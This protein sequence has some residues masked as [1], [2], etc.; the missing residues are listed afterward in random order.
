MF[1]YHQSA[2]GGETGAMLQMR[3]RSNMR[4]T[5]AA[6]IAESKCR[7][8]PPADGTAIYPSLFHLHQQSPRSRRLEHPAEEHDGDDEVNHVQF[9]TVFKMHDGKPAPFDSLSH[10]LE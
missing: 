10:A 5:T 4:R 9:E 7:I 1:S 6:S 2:D 3:T 8:A